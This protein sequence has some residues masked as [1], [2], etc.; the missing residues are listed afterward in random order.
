MP[1]I[2]VSQTSVPQSSSMRNVSSANLT[3]CADVGGSDSG[4]LRF[5]CFA[6][7]AGLSVI[8]P[9]RTAAPS[10]SLMIPWI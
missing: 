5:G 2:S 3:A 8:Q 9:Q 7:R 4:G 10:A 1:V 6:T